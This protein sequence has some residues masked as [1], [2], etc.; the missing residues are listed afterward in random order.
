MNQNTNEFIKTFLKIEKSEE[1]EN[2]SYSI[3]K[4]HQLFSFYS[5]DGNKSDFEMDKIFIDKD[6]KSFI[7]EIM[8]QNCIKDFIKGIN[9]CFISF[10][11][12]T[13]YK[14][15]CLIGNVKSNCTNK[16]NY[17]ILLRFLDE[18]LI[19]KEEKEF[20]YTIKISNFLI[21][22][23]NLIDL[24]YFGVKSKKN[25]EID[26]NIFLSN[27]YQI[28][29]DNDII[30]KMNKI[31]L[32]EYNDIIKYLHYI[33]IFL[34]K[35]QSNNIYNKSNICFIIYLFN[36]KT[37]EIISST[38]FIILLGSENLYEKYIANL[39]K[40]K[41]NNN[42]N[43]LI[44]NVKFSLEARNTFNSIIES[45][46]NNMSFNQLIKNKINSEICDSKLTIVLHN[47]CF[48]KDISKIKYRII[49]N[50]KPTKGNYQ[51]T[52]DVLI[53]LFDLWKIFNFKKEIKSEIIENKNNNDNIQFNLE[54]TIK[55]QKNKINNLTWKIE[56][57]NNKIKFL[58]TN[59]QKQINVLRNCFEFN[60]D[61]N[62]LLS[63]DEKSKEMKYV[64]KYKNY[65]NTI[66]DYE[67]TQKN[68][69]TNL[70]ESKKEIE[71]LKGKLNS[72]KEQQ[73]MI[74][75]YLAAQNSI[76]SKKSD[77]DNNRCN[78][79][80]K[81]IGELTQKIITKDKLISTLQK[82]LDKTKNIFLDFPNYTETL[83]EN[84]KMKKIIEE[85][86]YGNK[87]I[88][89]SLREKIENMKQ[90]EK[91]VLKEMKLNYD[92]I[93]FE[94]DNELLKLQKNLEE[95]AKDNNKTILELIKIYRTLINFISYIEKN[96]T[97]LEQNYKGLNETIKGINNGLNQSVY[98]N[99]FREL[100][101]K[102]Q[103]IIDLKDISK[104]SDLSKNSEIVRKET[105]KEKQE[106]KKSLETSKDKTIEELKE[107]Y[108]MLC[109]TFDLQ[110]KK[111]NNNLVIINSQ[112]RTIEKLER[113]LNLYRN[114]MEK[115]K[116]R[117]NSLSQ[118]FQE[119]KILQKSFSFNN[120]DFLKITKPFIIKRNKRT[121]NLY[122]FDSYRQ[123]T[124][125]N[126][127]NFN[128]FSS[129][130]NTNDKSIYNNK[131]IKEFLL[132]RK[133][134]KKVDKNKRPFSVSREKK[135]NLIS[136]SN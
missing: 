47:I 36:E 79:L 87:N 34:L 124:T 59:Y 55:E 100:K 1:K 118:D 93:I 51:N 73:D 63:G 60:G 56:K 8:C 18:L 85:N 35:L 103:N 7:Y 61:I 58:E 46:S 133:K 68:L 37:K 99:L 117:I 71:L 128:S 120:K 72:R 23:N 91:K 26:V 130:Q 28:N 112:K 27:A 129:F 22:Q 11:E 32:T 3:D 67:I 94:K 97:N 25:Y 69:E 62:I 105:K 123:K 86:K 75:Y 83:K 134:L 6:D 10:G 66:R 84:D 92:S 111:N 54:Y 4:N 125:N 88:E 44:K 48:G 136:S 74:N 13:N 108:K 57:L 77:K 113:E 24:T 43:K 114:I 81:Q 98:P 122:N 89:S 135:N 110:I 78:N 42:N 131:N 70:E 19:K 52:K 16:N 49:G 17:G 127:T 96:K 64:Q 107:K 5:L 102:N 45:I 2:T 80:L 106:I 50:I 65:Q 39:D 20:D 31:N 33:Q 41:I 115:K 101:L 121:N 116:I 109:M 14:F 9:F 15:E 40:E 38:S 53:F 29:N 132:I 95:K 126:N 21:F 82:E 104:D 90:K 119:N 12:T 30:N 76:I